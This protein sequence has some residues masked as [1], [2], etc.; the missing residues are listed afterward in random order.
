MIVFMMYC[1]ELSRKVST[2]IRIEGTTWNST[3]ELIAVTRCPVCGKDHDWSAKDFTLN[4]EIDAP[5]V[6]PLLLSAATTSLQNLQ[7]GQAY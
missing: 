7:C 3:P 2:G 4:D 5:R 1:P 6:L